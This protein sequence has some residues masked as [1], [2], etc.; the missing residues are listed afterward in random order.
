MSLVYKEQNKSYNKKE[1]IALTEKF[2]NST[3]ETYYYAYRLS[4]D[5]KFLDLSVNLLK[6]AINSSD[7]KLEQ[8]PTPSSI[9][10]EIN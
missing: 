4:G 8:Y 10:K 2:E 3:Y 7:Q 6:E 1:I 5:R 9:L